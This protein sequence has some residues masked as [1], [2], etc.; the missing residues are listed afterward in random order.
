MTYVFVEQPL[1]SPGSSKDRKD[2]RHLIHRHI[3]LSSKK[4]EDL[5]FRVL[6]VYWFYK[7]IGTTAVNCGQTHFVNEV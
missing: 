4:W 5:P 3:C 7:C 2:A 1:A 6:S